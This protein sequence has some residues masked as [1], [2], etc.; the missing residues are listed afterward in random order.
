[1]VAGRRT[2]LRVYITGATPGNYVGAAVLNFFGQG[3]P[4]FP[5][6]VVG[7]AVKAGSQAPR[8]LV[9]GDTVQIDFVVQ[10]NGAW[11]FNVR[12]SEYDSQ[13]NT[14][15]SAPPFQVLL[16][17]H[18]RRRIR[19]RLVR[20]RYQNAGRGLNLAAPT[21][22][23][24]WTALDFAQRVLPV[25]MPGFEILHESEELYDGD[26]T[27]IDPSAHDATWP[28][29]AGNNGTTGNLL[30]IMDRLVAT[31]SF[32]GDVI[33]VGLY[34]NGANQS[35]FAGWAVSRWIIS[36]GNGETLAHE[37]G[38]HVCRPQHAPCGNPPNVDLGYPTYGTHPAGS[39][40]EVGFDPLLEV[41]YDPATHRDLMSWCTPRWISPYNYQ[42]VFNC[43]TPLPPPASTSPSSA[44]TSGATIG[45]SKFL[46][47]R[48]P[49]RWIKVP[50][51]PVP[52][53]V[54]PPP[55]V[56]LTRARVVVRDAGGHELA[57]VPAK[58]EAA[59]FEAES[60]EPTWLDA[61]VPILPNAAILEAQ[62]DGETVFTDEISGRAP[63]VNVTWPSL[64]D[65]RNGFGRLTWM[66]DG[67]VDHIVV[68]ATADGGAT[69][70]ARVLPAAQ[71]SL[72]LGPEMLRPGAECRI[73]VLGLHGSR[74]GRAVSELFVVARRL[75]ELLI[76]KDADPAVHSP[77]R[78][79]R[80]S[81]A[82]YAPEALIS[83]FSDIDGKL[84]EGAF[85]T[86]PRLRPGRHVIEA[87]SDQPFEMPAQVVVEVTD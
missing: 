73:E 2:V 49:P 21:V 22:Q 25:P 6:I 77:G 20:I 35:G 43:L 5:P 42:I 40:G 85:L 76:M 7:T 8:R 30:N 87:R 39:I 11:I 80:L 46:L 55:L 67:N 57:A 19:V 65:L 32:P 64:A 75:S 12:A 71:R 54:Q 47:I 51:P 82:S 74:A 23:N 62:I 50:L 37:F 17:F 33:Y 16:T 60:Q 70:I 29:F 78:R 56:D 27:R 41:A 45:S 38:H 79:L 36:D 24:F 81:A 14:L 58:L 26:F 44:G 28:G 84:G 66:I 9:A 68:R 18:Y 48:L 61:E 63:V 86:L 3:P 52:R 1:M 10:T 13:W 59:S 4:G 72:D 31:E 69:W 53:T 34:P 15:S 83:W